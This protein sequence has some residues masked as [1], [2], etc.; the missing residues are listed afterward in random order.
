MIGHKKLKNLH[1]AHNSIKAQLPW[2]VRC[3][4]PNPE[5]T[6]DVAMKFVAP[7]VSMN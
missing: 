7:G 3:G 2:L 4:H 1:V 5:G 6:V